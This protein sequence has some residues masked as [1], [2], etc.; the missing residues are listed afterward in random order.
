MPEHTV[1]FGCRPAAWHE[2][3]LSSRATRAIL[4]AADHRIL[5]MRCLKQSDAHFRGHCGVIWHGSLCLGAGQ[6][7]IRPRV[8]AKCKH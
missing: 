6:R 3:G 5:R 7:C 8:R 4:Y 1:Q 2:Q